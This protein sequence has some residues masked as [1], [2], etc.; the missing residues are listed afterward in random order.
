M[1]DL[2]RTID[3][4]EEQVKQLRSR[5]HQIRT[6]EMIDLMDQS[7]LSSIT[8]NGMVFEKD[9]ELNGSFPKI[10]SN[11]YVDAIGY[12]KDTGNDDLL[13]TELS[14]NFQKGQDNLAW[15]ICRE[16]KASGQCEPVLQSTVHP[17][18]LKAFARR[19]LKEG[20][21]IDLAKV[22]LSM[23]NI[24]KTKEKK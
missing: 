9:S 2:E 13:R 6:V 11:N 21:D 17:M 3:E 10:G 23:F 18:T 20:K 4:L 22:G 1:S 12:L 7:S 14:V 19:A 5:R 24:I 8:Y 15:N 16:L